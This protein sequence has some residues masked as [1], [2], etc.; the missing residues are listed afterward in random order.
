MKNITI[1][2]TVLG[3]YSI[4]RFESRRLWNV[5]RAS[6]A[7]HTDLLSFHRRTGQRFD[8]SFRHLSQL[9]P[10]TRAKIEADIVRDIR[11]HPQAWEHPEVAEVVES[12]PMAPNL[13]LDQ[14]FDYFFNGTASIA[15]LTRYCAAGTGTTTPAVSDT[16]LGA[17]VVRTGT[18]VTT[19]GSCGT[20][21]TASSVVYK[22]THDFPVETVARNY[23]ELGW[24]PASSAGAN[25]AIRVLISGGTVTVA[26][27]QQLRVVHELTLNCSPTTTQTGT[28]TVSNWPISPATDTAITWAH[29]S[30]GFGTVDTNGYAGAGPI[31][32]ADSEG[33]AP[34]AWTGCTLAAWRSAASVWGSLDWNV[35]AP[36]GAG[37][38]L[39]YTPGSFS[40]TLQLGY[41]PAAAWGSA[42][43]RAY[44]FQ[45]YYWNYGSY[46]QRSVFPIVVRFDQLQTKPD[47]HKLR[48]PGFTLSLSR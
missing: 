30:F 2:N 10:I 12:R 15:N 42:S 20:A 37:G 39:T 9:A 5:R 8:G 47:T 44:G 14:G 33:W 32:P 35:A 48:L 25:L 38:W 41:V 26:I 34:M 27:G 6:A 40:R 22:R 11:E 31:E 13:E 43:I 17:E 1:S 16:A 19:S 46:S 3:K 45:H 28:A 36:Y 4:E 21:Y 18:M 7:R 24:S 29:Q 23:T